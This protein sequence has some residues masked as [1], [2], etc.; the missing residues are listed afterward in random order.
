M[1]VAVRD[2]GAQG[3][4]TLSAFAFHA[5]PPPG[6]WMNDP[7]ALLLRDGR[8]QLLAQHSASPATLAIGWGHWSSADL[9]G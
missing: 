1:A 5:A 8:W 3:D 9:L 6:T 7:N 2:R 4:R